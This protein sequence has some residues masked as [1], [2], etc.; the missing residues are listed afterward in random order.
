ML[1]AWWASND[2]STFLSFIFE[3]N[4]FLCSIPFNNEILYKI[5]KKN[6]GLNVGLNKTEKNAIKFLLE[7]QVIL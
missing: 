5:E 6:V 3:P 4:Y 2:S 7:I 1:L